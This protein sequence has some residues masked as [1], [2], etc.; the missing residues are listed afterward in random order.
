MQGSQSVGCDCRREAQKSTRGVMESLQKTFLLA[1]YRIVTFLGNY[2]SPVGQGS[3]QLFGIHCI[4]KGPIKWAEWH[5]AWHK[6]LKLYTLP[7]KGVEGYPR[8]IPRD[9]PSMVQRIQLGL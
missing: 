5:K 4:K 8:D 6:Q 2:C 9:A 7:F 3:H 1:M